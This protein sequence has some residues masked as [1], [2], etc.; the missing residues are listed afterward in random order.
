MQENLLQFFDELSTEQQTFLKKQI[1][2]IDFEYIK[3][4]T[5]KYVLNKPQTDIPNN[6]EP[7]PYYPLKSKNDADAKLY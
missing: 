1:D 7:A 5:Q 6:I 4:L 3:E 2:N